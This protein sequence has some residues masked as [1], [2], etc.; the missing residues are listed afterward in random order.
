[1]WF[2][3]LQRDPPQAWRTRP[4]HPVDTSTRPHSP[5]GKGVNKNA[6]DWL[7]TNEMSHLNEM[8][9]VMEQMPQVLKHQVLW[10]PNDSKVSPF[11]QRLGGESFRS[12]CPSIHSSSRSLALLDLRKLHLRVLR[13]AANGASQ[14]VCP[15]SSEK[16]NRQV[17]SVPAFFSSG[18]TQGQG[19]HLLPPLGGSYISHV[20]GM[21]PNM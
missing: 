7:V 12:F 18:R 21:R 1:M 4:L 14:K 9:F 16:L 19:I 10:I 3:Q 2:R 11:H 13:R 6:G 15:G 17:T 5:H 8:S 20:T